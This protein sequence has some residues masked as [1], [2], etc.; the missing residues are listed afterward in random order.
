[1]IAQVINKNISKRCFNTARSFSTNKLILKDI[2]VISDGILENERQ[3]IALA[4]GL[5]LDYEVHRV[6]RKKCNII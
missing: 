4:K 3:S 5:N 2:W 6:V 1:M